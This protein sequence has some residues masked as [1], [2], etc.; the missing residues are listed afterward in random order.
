MG[1]S[2][3][4]SVVQ[5]DGTIKS[6]EQQVSLLVGKRVQVSH[7]FVDG[8]LV[9]VLKNLD[10]EMNG[11]LYLMDEEDNEDAV[12][13]SSMGKQTDT[14][15]MLD[16]AWTPYTYKQLQQMFADVC[17]ELH[18]QAPYFNVI[19][20]DRKKDILHLMEERRKSHPEEVDDE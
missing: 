10:I 12:V 17:I 6:L 9:L 16:N 19:T 8:D 4:V 5:N 18:K 1:C 3:E 13:V 14:D 7:K 20:E 15:P 2:N 11:E